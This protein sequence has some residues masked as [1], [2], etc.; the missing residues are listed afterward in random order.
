MS[1]PL[2]PPEAECPNCSRSNVL[3]GY[4]GRPC[5]RCSSVDTGLIVPSHEFN[6]AMWEERA[7][8]DILIRK[9]LFG[10]PGNTA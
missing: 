2:P 9:R 4:D 8:L 10:T 1:E 5:L 3:T 7:L 6:L